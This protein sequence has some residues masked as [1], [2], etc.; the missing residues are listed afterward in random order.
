MADTRWCN[1]LRCVARMAAVLLAG[2][3][4]LLLCNEGAVGQWRL[5]WLPARLSAPDE[6]MVTLVLGGGLLL[7]LG[8]FWERWGAEVDVGIAGLFV[9]CCLVMARTHPKLL[10]V[11]GLVLPIMLFLLNGDGKGGHAR[12]AH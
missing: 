1:G 11:A 6:L 8:W 2:L 7:A 9:V 4:V 5:H 12:P 3:G 10:L